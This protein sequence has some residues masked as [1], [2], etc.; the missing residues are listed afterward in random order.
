MSQKQRPCVS[1]IPSPDGRLVYVET[2][3]ECYMYKERVTNSTIRGSGKIMTIIPEKIYFDMD[4]VLADF[5]RGVRELCGIEP[6]L[7][8]KG[9]K[10]GDDDLMWEKIRMQEH[11]YDRLEIA[12]GAREMFDL[13][14][15]RYGAR[16]EVLSA[17]P[18]PEK[19]I[20]TAGEDKI[21]WMKRLFP[22]QVVVNIVFRE[23]KPRFCKG[24]GC[25]LIDDYNENVMS[26]QRKGGTAIY[27]ISP[28]S[29]ITK[30]QEMG[31]L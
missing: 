28:E 15:S 22:E 26:W 8:G 23:E 16:C 7:Q 25:I 11:F 24:K 5:N 14:Y 2:V 12:P 21:R 30:L 10:P 29:T 4:G 18:K 31:L 27:H 17:I 19:G 13:V 1:L 9:W 3:V 20:T 6:P